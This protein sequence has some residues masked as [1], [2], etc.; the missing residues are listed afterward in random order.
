MCV[1]AIVA[2][3][4]DV[5]GSVFVDAI[6]AT[7]MRGGGGVRRRGDSR[8]LNMERIEIEIRVR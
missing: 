7:K 5:R 4:D 6:L 1:W 8:A 3:S 2:T